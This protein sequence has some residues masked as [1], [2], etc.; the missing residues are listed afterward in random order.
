MLRELSDRTHQVFTG[1]AVRK[2]TVRS[3]KVTGTAVTFRRLSD[4]EIDAYVESGDPLDKA[5]A[6]GIQ[7]AAARFVEHID[8]NYQSVVGL[9][10]TVVERLLHSVHSE[11]LPG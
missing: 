11:D 4:E 8:G 6:Y 1:V 3:G 5:G 2:G 10:L 9:P 7:G